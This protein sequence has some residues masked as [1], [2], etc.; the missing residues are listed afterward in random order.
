MILTAAFVLSFCGAAQNTNKQADANGAK[1]STG[2]F[3]LL[4][5]WNA[6]ISADDKASVAFG[7]SSVSRS[8]KGSITIQ[9]DPNIPVGAFYELYK[10]IR[11]VKP[12]EV[13]QMTAWIKTD[14]Q[15][16][17]AGAFMG[18]GALEPN[19]PYHRFVSGDSER[20]T[21]T[22]DWTKVS[23]VLFVPENVHTIRQIILIGGSGQAYFDEIELK[24]ID[25]L[26]S[27][28]RQTVAVEV[29][30]EVTTDDFI[31]FGYE[32][33]AFFYTDEN[34]RHG[35]TEQDIKLRNDRIVELAPGVIATLFWWDAISPTHDVNHITYDTELMRAMI[36]TLR[37][38]Q[39]A[40]RK[41]FM[42]D[43]HWGWTKDNFTYNEKNVE[44]G[45]KAYADVIQ[46]LVKEQG[47]KCLKYI[48]VSGEVDMTFEALGGSFETYLKA[49]RILRDELNKA[50]LQDVVVIGD[51]SGGF[52]WI[53]RIVPILDNIFG[54]YTI[55]E[56]PEV[57]QYSLIDYRIDKITEIIHKRSTPI[58]TAN[59]KKYKP[60]FLYE[61]GVLE[62]KTLGI[63]DKT[64]SVT[65]T[66]EYGLYC[67]NTAISGL[68][69]GVAGGSVW[70]L[71]SMYYPGQSKMNFGTWEFKDKGWETR[72]NYYGF[73]LFSK[74]AR[75]GMK[76]LKVEVGPHLYDVS[77]AALKDDAG[78]YLVYLLNLSDKMV[79]VAVSGV[80]EGRYDV[81]EYSR[82]NIP[83]IQDADY[84]K[85][86]ALKTD[87]IWNATEK[88]ITLRPQS[89]VLL[90]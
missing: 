36:R 1:Q 47:L 30:K 34:F 81:Y 65:P 42:G 84:G 48:C 56:Y 5:G 4:D 45:A 57:T 13:Y 68:N 71:H 12:G 69:R 35:I 66:Y 90:K 55:H 46:Y 11:D 23:C 70:C 19:Y 15:A 61:I 59:G 75:A 24:K 53:D 74:Y 3:E 51:K 82:D 21:K 17:G 6:N 60:V 9:V 18:I 33:D 88:K 7:V 29:T 14:N 79:D 50:G 32:D 78:H 25:T 73:G 86:D 40:G 43:V 44:R 41:V 49:C 27:V 62:G 80:A 38:H 2:V 10:D 20:L 22:S 83:S 67:A 26:E 54:I 77:A 89:I 58:E 8:G 28:D 85:I 16:D 39:E 37:P 64:W 72:P 63:P 87:R 76:P 52:V 31:G